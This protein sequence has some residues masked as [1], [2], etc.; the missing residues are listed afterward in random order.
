M[1]S[2]LS[3]LQ[4][5]GKK[6]D[7]ALKLAKS[8]DLLFQVQTKLKEL[9]LV[10]EA[11]NGLLIYLALISRLVNKPISIILKAG[12]SAGK[13][14]LVKT[15]SMLFPVEAYIELT[16]LSPKALVYLNEP[17]KHRFSFYLD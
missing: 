5:L 13:S 9:G 4:F 1:P 12:S 2:I 3:T 6:R 17:F 11:L 15:V 14:F 8:P 10:G 7:E 16:G